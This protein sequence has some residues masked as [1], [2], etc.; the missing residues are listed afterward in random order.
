MSLKKW[1]FSLR[2]EDCLAGSQEKSR[3][4][5]PGRDGGRRMV[6]NARDH[7]TRRNKTHSKNWKKTGMGW[8]NM[9]LRRRRKSAS[10]SR[11]PEDISSASDTE[12][13]SQAAKWLARGSLS[14][15]PCSKCPVWASRPYPLSSHSPHSPLSSS[16]LTFPQPLFY[17]LSTST[18]HSPALPHSP[19]KPA[20]VLPAT[21]PG[22]QTSIS[23]YLLLKTR[24]S[25]NQKRAP[26]IRDLSCAVPD[27]TLHIFFPIQSSQ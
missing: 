2:S 4:P 23:R 7:A 22:N 8:C 6:Q 11:G 10:K 27:T 18:C 20:W 3:V 24:Q 21:F 26:F 9:R 1:A 5:G 19:F 13:G 16:L 17:Y 14:K 25:I 15:G 12:V